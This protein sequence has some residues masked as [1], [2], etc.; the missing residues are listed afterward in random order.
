VATSSSSASISG[1]CCCCAEPRSCVSGAGGWGWRRKHD[2]VLLY[3][4]RRRAVRHLLRRILLL[5]PPPPPPPTQVRGN[6]V[7][8]VSAASTT[9]MP[10]WQTFPPHILLYA[11]AMSGIH[12]RASMPAVGSASGAFEPMITGRLADAHG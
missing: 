8:I 5:D 3:H 11:S 1:R 4:N 2:A 10:D 9:H 7:H 12:G 6:H